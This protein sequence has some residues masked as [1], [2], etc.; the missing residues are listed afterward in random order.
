MSIH[1]IA[2]LAM[3]RVIS[4]LRL[5]STQIYG[6]LS[7]NILCERTN[8]NKGTI[9]A[10]KVAELR[11]MRA[12]LLR[13][14]LKELQESVAATSAAV[15][16][17]RAPFDKAYQDWCRTLGPGEYEVLRQERRECSL[18]SEK[19]VVSSFL[20]TG[21]GLKMSAVVAV[22]ASVNFILPQADLHRDYVL[23]YLNVHKVQRELCRF[24][25]SPVPTSG[26]SR[27][28][29][30]QQ[31]LR[32]KGL[33]S[34][35]NFVSEF[36]IIHEK[37]I[38]ATVSL[39]SLGRSR[40]SPSGLWPEDDD[41]S[42]CRE[43]AA[44]AGPAT[45]ETIAKGSVQA[46]QRNDP[47]TGLRC[48]YDM[49][50]L[51]SPIPTFRDLLVRV[52]TSGDCPT[53]ARLPNSQDQRSVDACNLSALSISQPSNHDEQECDAPMGIPE[54]TSYLATQQ[55]RQLSQCSGHSNS[56]ERNHG[57]RE[58]LGF[59]SDFLQE[60]RESG[61]W[62]RIGMDL[63]G[64]NQPAAKDTPVA[65]LAACRPYILIEFWGLQVGRKQ[66][67]FQMPQ[68]YSFLIGSFC[69]SNRSLYRVESMAPSK[70]KAVTRD[71]EDV[72][73]PSV[74]TGASQDNFDRS[75]ITVFQQ[76]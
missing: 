8:F 32:Q 43:A 60:E 25:T 13:P 21:L 50:V 73:Q 7:K 46:V 12:N 28:K 59:R 3:P 35:Y 72:A 27:T 55:Y 56:F 64:H 68:K 53:F 47:R 49:S 29:H 36:Q 66:L 65:G 71:L 19:L 42:G 26:R 52:L 37:F 38:P 39:N 48:T 40:S 41:D 51:Q 23:R 4:N 17:L 30:T 11:R 1:H 70:S 62:K 44:G 15:Q 45:R 75:E 16:E 22:S 20:L 67:K 61:A 34:N 76:L 9:S 33:A 5:T 31:G 74:F 6:T 18:Q 2:A 58:G 10:E 24:G 57:T 14:T 69:D 54:L 63:N